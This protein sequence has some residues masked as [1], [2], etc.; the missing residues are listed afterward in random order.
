MEAGATVVNDVSG[1]ERDPLMRKTVAALGVPYIAMHM[2]GDAATMMSATD[3][4]QQGDLINGIRVELY[5][6]VRKALHAGVH[7]WNIIVDPGIGFA[8]TSQ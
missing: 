4:S 7:R 2:R 5:D 8:K 1:G 3:Y 6:R